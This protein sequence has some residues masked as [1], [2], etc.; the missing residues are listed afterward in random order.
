[1]ER[2]TR[3][4]VVVPGRLAS[5]IQRLAAA[6]AHQHGLQVMTVEQLTARLA[7][8]M[9]QA[10]DGESLRMAVQSILPG[11]ALGELDR[12]KAL[13]GLVGAAVDTLEKSWRAGLNL[14]SMASQHPRLA[15]MA[16]LEA[17]VISALPPALLRPSDLVSAALQR[18]PHAPTLLGPIDVIGVTELSP[19]WRPL[20]EALTTRVNVRWIAGPRSTPPWLDG[21]S[22]QI[23]R[24]AACKPEI[25]SVSAATAY[26]EVIECL[27][28]ARE[29][30]ASGRAKPQEIGIASVASIDYD[31][32]FLALR[33]QANLGLHF[34]HGVKVMASREG[35]AAAALADVLIRGLS[36][37]HVRRLAALLSG[38]PGPFRALPERWTQLLPEDAPLT[39]AESWT[40]WLSS[41]KASDWPGGTDQSAAVREIIELL[42]RG[43]SAA[44]AAGDFLLSG[45]VLAIWRSALRA[46]PAASVDLTLETLRQDD[47]IE[48]CT[49]VAW[50]PASALAACPRPFV[51]LLGLN[52]SRWPRGIVEDRLLSDH[53]IPTAELD[54]LPLGAADRRDF[55]TILATTERQVVL[56]HARRDE[57]GRLLGRS[58]LLQ[59]QAKATYL[60][61][62]RVPLHAFS[63]TDRLTARPQEFGTHPQAITA[64]SCWRN[65][66]RSELTPHDGLIRPDHPVINAILERTQ[67]ATSLQHLLRNPLGFLWRYALRWR[68]PESGEEPLVLESSSMGELVHALLNRTLSALQAAGG[69]SST[70]PEHIAAAIED[71]ARNLSHEWESQRP[72][73][74]RLIWHK[75]LDDARELSRRAF[76]LTEKSETGASTYSEVPFGG[77]APKLEGPLPWDATAPVE[78]PNTG[79]QI[80]GYIDRLDVSADKS[81]ARVYDFKT[82]KAL[83]ADAVLAGGKELQRCL[84]AFAVKALLGENVSTTTSLLFLREKLNLALENPDATLAQISR[85]L[86]EARANLL[87]GSAVIGPD[88]GGDFDELTFALP[89]NASAGYCRRKMAAVIERLGGATELWETP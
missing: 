68:S 60:R 24:S 82:G 18:I 23:V 57:E 59:N 56:S 40:R 36:Q 69:A 49:S 80:K 55:N 33:A 88:S 10:V 7:G 83:K 17:A 29:L 65:R 78:I 67:S 27:R 58:V 1:M 74:P 25:L 53:I 86:G 11:T 64:L 47:D 13:P 34:V 19:C 9:V 4:T 73:P 39:G 42:S 72:I 3:R 20:L 62:N 14:Q 30:I 8:G 66:M 15:S 75:A 37:S 76:E 5:R 46:G 89:A 63:Q 31:D 70:S 44:E 79:F 21:D 48:P 28:W 6:R 32:H 35:Q 52:S 26:H 41:L 2:V 81:R 77:E 85:Y 45:R 84:Y 87:A 71:A 12:I 50:M 22:I 54:P 51:R 43:T 61:R 16:R 38:C